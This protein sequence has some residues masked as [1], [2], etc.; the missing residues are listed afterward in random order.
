MRVAFVFWDSNFET[1]AH[2][3]LKILEIK[4]D[5]ITVHLAWVHLHGAFFFNKYVHYYKC[6]FSSL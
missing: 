2:L 4:N 1:S 6:I 5:L 3:D